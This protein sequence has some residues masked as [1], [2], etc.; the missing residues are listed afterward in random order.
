MQI[1][2]FGYEYEA[3]YFGGPADGLEST[4]VTFDTSPPPEISC[5]E[6]HNLI[7]SKTPIGKHF[8]KRNPSADTRVGVYILENPP[9]EYTDDDTLIYHFMEMMFYAD[10]VKKY[11]D[12]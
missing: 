1:E 11:G 9:D 4:V 3:K 5:L 8:F 6:L 12:E 10:F 2:G 7:E